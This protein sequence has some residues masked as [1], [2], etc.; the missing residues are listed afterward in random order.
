[1]KTNKVLSLA[2]VGLFA[3]SSAGCDKKVVTETTPAP[4]TEIAAATPVPATTPDEKAANWQRI[5]DLRAGKALSTSSAT[6]VPHLIMGDNKA[7]YIAP[8]Q[9]AQEK[10]TE[11]LASQRFQDEQAFYA[12]KIAGA[13]KM[14][15][16][17]Q[18]T[19]WSDLNHD[20][21]TALRTEYET[22]RN[23]KAEGQEDADKMDA[24]YKKMGWKD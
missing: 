1:M 8:K 11:K 2:A 24:Y 9:T 4:Q 5:L 14:G 17:E 22:I 19:K 12:R 23:L 16:L 20:Q 13:I 10:R 21:Q 3:L 15:A 18:G 7:A 6:V